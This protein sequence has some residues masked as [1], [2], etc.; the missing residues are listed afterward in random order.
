[1]PCMGF[2]KTVGKLLVCQ[3]LGL[4]TLCTTKISQGSRQFSSAN[5]IA[6]VGPHEGF[7]FRLH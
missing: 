7:R 6:E 2:W 3:A 1:M 4:G 5:L